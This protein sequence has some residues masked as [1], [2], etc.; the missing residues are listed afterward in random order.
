MKRVILS[1]FTLALCLFA[2]SE[3]QT[4]YYQSEAEFLSDQ[5]VSKYKVSGKIYIRADFDSQGK[6]IL[7]SIINEQ[8]DMTRF[9]RY[10]YADSTDD[11]STKEIL[12]NDTVMVQKTTFGHEEKTEAYIEYVY[13]VDTVKR[14]NDRFTIQTF[15]KSG[16][17][18]TYQFLDVD[19]FEYGNI[20]FEYDSLG[21]MSKQEWIKRPSGKSMRKWLYATDPI[22][23]VTHILEYDS[24]NTLAFEINLAADGTEVIL[25]FLSPE[26]SSLVNHS[27][28]GYKL[29]GDL[30]YGFLAWTLS[31]STWRHL[32]DTLRF[33]MSK[34]E[35]K[36]GNHLID[37]RVDT[38]MI[39]SLEYDVTFTGF[40]TKEYVAN[41]R[42]IRNLV[43]DNSPPILTLNVDP[44]INQPEFGFSVSESMERAFVMW[45]PDNVDF[46]TSIDTIQFIENELIPDSGKMILTNQTDLQ[47]SVIY[48]LEMIGIDKA[49][50]ISI[51][52][53]VDSIHYD[54]TAP[55]FSLTN[56]PLASFI[57][58]GNTTFS[59]DEAIQSWK[60]EIRQMAGLKDVNAPH[61]IDREMI[62]EER[63][64]FK[65]DV[66]ESIMLVDGAMYR[67]S[68]SG[69]DLAGNISKIVNVDSIFY[70]ISPPVLTLIYPIN[71]V[72][73]R[74]PSVSFAFNE[75]L[76]AAEFR[77]DRTDGTAD[78][79]SPRI[80][81]LL[82]DELTKGE[83]IRINL[84]QEPELVDGTEYALTLTGIDYAGN[85]GELIQI[86]HILFDASP[87]KF[88]DLMPLNGS[89]L[90]HHNLSYTLS[91]KLH[92]GSIKWTRTGGEEDP[93]NNYRMNLAKEELESGIHADI[94]LRNNPRLVDG[95]IY[96]LEFRG[97]D[98]AGNQSDTLMIED[99]LYDFS[100]PIISVP[101]P[102]SEM[103]LN[104]THISYSLSEKLNKGM[105]VWNPTE[106][107]GE[108]NDPF[109]VIWS[110]QDK[111]PGEH[112]EIEI[113]G[114]SDVLENVLYSI[115]FN[116]SDRAGNH[117]EEVILSNIMYDFTPPDISL[118]FPESGTAVNHKEI[119]FSLSEDLLSAEV[120]WE[121]M[122]GRDDNN[123]PHIQPLVGFE[124]NA[125]NKDNQVI[126]RA[127]LLVDGTI[128]RVFIRGK[129]PAG[130]ES[131]I[132]TIEN[133]LYDIT[134]PVLTPLY[135]QDDQYISTPAIG[136]SINED[137][138]E[139]SVLYRFVG[140]KPD[141]NSPYIFNMKDAM[142]KK[143]DHQD[144]FLLNGPTLVEQ[145]I[146][147]V[148]F[149]GRDRAG[150]MIANKTIQRIIFDSTPPR[151]SITMPKEN[152]AVN[153]T[154]VSFNNS[155][156]LKTAFM[157]WS[158]SG[159]TTVTESPKI[160]VLE[161]QE[162]N[163]GLTTNIVL[164]NQPNLVDGSTYDLQFYATDFAGNY[165]DT[166]YVNNI[167]Y[168][169]TPPVIEIVSPNSQIISALTDIEY[170]LSENI[171]TG[172]IAWNGKDI[173]GAPLHKLFEIAE[174]A[175]KKGIHHSDTY[176]QPILTDGGLYNISIKATDPAGNQATPV[177]ITEFRVDRTPPE[178]TNL[179]PKSNS[180]INSDDIIFTISEVL[181]SGK[182]M[183]SGNQNFTID[184]SPEELK[185]ASKNPNFVG[186]MRNLKDGTNYT[187]SVIGTDFAGNNSEP[188]I[189]TNIIY[190]ISMPILNIISPV[191]DSYITNS[192][193]KISLNETLKSGS[194][195]W[196]SSEYEESQ[197]DL[198]LEYLAKGIHIISGSLLSIKEN[199]PNTI[200]F[201]G[202]DLAGNEG[203][204]ED[205]INVTYDGTPPEIKLTEPSSN[206]SVNHTRF[207]FS[208]NETL[209]SGNITWTATDGA[210]EASPHRLQLTDALLKVGEYND[211]SM[212]R[213]N[214]VDGVFYSIAIQGFDR[215]E[216]LS[217]ISILE[218]IKYDITQP[219]FIHISPSSDTLLNSITLSYN[220]TEDL[221]EG[222]ISIGKTKNLGQGKFELKLDGNRLK[223]GIGGGELPPSV[224]LESGIVYEM[225]FYGK[226][227]AGNETSPT[228]ITDIKFD[229]EK[230]NIAL[231]APESNTFV[232]QSSISF[233]ISEHLKEGSIELLQNGQ[234]PIRVA[235]SG[236]YLNANNFNNVTIPGLDVWEDGGVYSI[237]LSGT[238][239]AG[240]VGDAATNS[241]I[242]YDINPPE[243]NILNP[244]SNSE[245]REETFSYSINENVKEATLTIKRTDGEM[246]SESPHFIQ[247][248]GAELEKGRK[249]LSAL[250]FL[251]TNRPNLVNGAIYNYSVSTVDF[252]GN[253]ATSNVVSD[254]GF[255]NEP[256]IISISQPLDSE[257]IKTSDVSYMLSDNLAWGKIRF[258]QF[259]GTQDPNSPHIHEM[260][261]IEMEQGMHSG[262][263]L[264]IMDKLAD[265]GR[266]TISIE[267][268]DNAGNIAK[269][270][271]ATN[272]LFDVKPP[273]L[274]LNYP[275][276]S[277]KVN[278][279]TVSFSSS[280]KM[281]D[282]SI[283]F[284]RTGGAPDPGSPH[285]YQLAEDELSNGIHEL[286]NVNHPLQDGSIYTISFD[287][288]DFAGN[289]SETVTL[290]EI[291]YD[292]TDPALSIHY[293]EAKSFHQNLMVNIFSD[294]NLKKGDINLIQTGGQID[295]KSPHTFSLE[296]NHL[297]PGEYSLD[298][299]SMELVSG[300]TYSISY[301]GEDLAGNVA[302]TVVVENIQIDRDRPFLEITSPLVDTFV[303]HT[304]FGI[305]IG[306]T[307]QEAAIS[308]TR[309]SGEPDPNSP[310]QQL[311]TGQYLLAG[312]Y[313]NILLSNSPK[314]VSDV[315]YSMALHGVDLAG[316]SAT[317]HLTE[318]HFDNQPPSFTHYLPVTKMFI[319]DPNVQFEID[320]LL[321][322]GSIVWSATG[323]ET[324]PLS[325]RN[326]EFSESEL[327]N[328]MP[329]LGSLSFQTE[330]QDGTVYSLLATG[331]DRAGNSTRIDLAH[332][333]TYDVSKPM[334]T[335]LF[336]KMTS[337]INSPLVKFTI[338]ETL[339]S[340]AFTWKYMGGTDDPSVPHRVDFTS[341]M[342]SA[343]SH[344]SETVIQPDLV[345]GTMY[346][347]TFEGADFSGNIGKKLVMNIVY[348][349][350][351]PTLE[352]LYPENNST[353]N[354]SKLAYKISEPL[355]EGSITYIQTGGT[356]DPSSPH[357]VSL[358]D[359][360]LEIVQL[361][362]THLSNSAT[363]QDGS[364]YLVKFKGMDLANNSNTSNS[365]LNVSN[366]VLYDITKPKILFQKPSG[367]QV[368]LGPNLTYSNS[369]LLT[370]ATV[371]FSRTGGNPDAQAPHAILLIDDELNAGEHPNIELN[372]M[373]ELSP[374]TEY[375]LS[376]S[377]KDIAGNEN[378]PVSIN[379]I[380]YVRSLE[381]NWYWQGPIMQVVWT[382]TPLNGSFGLTGEFAEGAAIGSKISNQ[383]FGTYTI[384]Y[385]SSPWILETEQTDTGE[386]RFSLI[387]FIGPNR[388]KV[389]TK[390]KKNPTS[391]SDGEI[392]E[393]DYKP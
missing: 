118:T 142:L 337:R 42:I 304:R 218:N 216:N 309:V 67:F 173:S 121:K 384:D 391:W 264:N 176:I 282:G 40:T 231:F 180:F 295:P 34:A 38:L 54:I 182:V 64:E 300:S 189:E 87:P 310:H 215:A 55:R 162:L 48:Q 47:D 63:S 272:V 197:I 198:G 41:K 260:S 132:P 69:V 322:N 330:L 16:R 137:L 294:E 291:N 389:L 205:I 134:A 166:V 308:W 133:I 10:T 358:Q 357:S 270:A 202:V 93:K 185:T 193:M 143:G 199:I 263:D 318:M 24:T 28:V 155:E 288:M 273:M 356:T 341:E 280:E 259:G 222:K 65:L 367:N 56:P 125:G 105:I 255:D 57:N 382:F 80:V 350:I 323:G 392:M 116:G 362:P 83:K 373:N 351:P 149:S 191:S 283:T 267:G 271:Q 286:I 178:I 23:N 99:I 353:I 324:D 390:A 161:G 119:S 329:T 247:L 78:S 258:I 338:N 261:G 340:G 296:A 301:S 184:L 345:T 200:K 82:K 152:S 49:G 321:V 113:E 115:S 120:I 299:T 157:V 290:T 316:N 227:L 314:L 220:L 265:G 302:T 195:T 174:K 76:Q 374:G 43:F 243:I 140:G 179:F 327:A 223:A 12:I 217:E 348:D 369:E 7:K 303:N 208:T 371:N 214:L 175:A 364:I 277:S 241:N 347:I 81:P 331:T 160:I 246:D 344:S 275:I 307:L 349:D 36:T 58:N 122:G 52:V 210:D 281:A 170:S 18:E 111:K 385:S 192:D 203:I 209:S 35:I 219:A 79:S 91:E 224:G 249:D 346:R 108:L 135:P 71:D 70:D 279:S 326:I 383:T 145:G 100:K 95:G 110:D 336:P 159:G 72:A 361:S 17:V 172:S 335:N 94:T 26:D 297:N 66:T 2:L 138:F 50:N 61:I 334:F 31:D 73:I 77:W 211:Y 332:G 169:I 238:D 386:K 27:R 30:E 164:K 317:A 53:K 11:L 245:I 32:Q 232:R 287:G 45:I 237:T 90:N 387:E 274:T 252:A 256:P 239:L 244:I 313:D 188:L 86:Q 234:Q 213:L 168:D 315:T 377:G 62:S 60:L 378:D 268:G 251:S 25:H 102:L 262:F 177:T 89:A 276:P 359:L 75:N 150:N 183:I 39:D 230:P 365:I 240:N 372:N 46:N 21:Y 233:G 141:S 225:E 319:K 101:H 376:F 14:W 360:E 97:S 130:N 370:T 167:L 284:F 44:H 139:G 5:P 343:G 37:W 9:E 379:G 74:D 146:Y 305:R 242:S 253:E 98:R 194:I 393:Y 298:L 144:V 136:F 289:R 333:L 339:K 293:P 235:L 147:T 320:E 248:T 109:E 269:V 22:T 104:H 257:Q 84:E 196:I 171:A 92:E 20:R 1:I 250:Y 187:I 292:I 207:S 186:H 15:N 306:E 368:M 6:L 201:T 3:D 128:Y 59:T 127:P 212:D 123:S 153:H 13:G 117:A 148:E 221:T 88:T 375:S 107:D 278:H 131:N 181:A 154:K 355:S 226:D 311:L 328:G 103:I 114:M 190:D 266:Y 8:G 68:V 381:G 354:N 229:S 29:D 158:Q 85:E 342:L 285:V 126:V 312:K 388:I 366:D 51:P 254:V 163:D 124:L 96:K 236:E 206:S 204:A 228:N 380:T 129:D 352:L 19:A 106:T 112:L 4:K 363:L 325:P 33:Q 151:L 156:K 165:S